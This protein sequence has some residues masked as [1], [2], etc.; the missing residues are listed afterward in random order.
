[1]FIFGLAPKKKKPRLRF[2][3]PV[4]CF[5]RR[6]NLVFEKTYSE[7]WDAHLKLEK[8]SGFKIN[9]ILV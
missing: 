1:M 8:Q 2:L 7:F 4:F 9:R 5:G 3:T 6:P